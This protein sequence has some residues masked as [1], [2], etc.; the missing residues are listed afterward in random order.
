MQIFHKIDA[1]HSSDFRT[2]IASTHILKMFIR[3][4]DRLRT[5]HSL[6]FYFLIGAAAIENKP[7]SAKKLNGKIIII[8]NSNPI[9]KHILIG[10]RIAVFR[11]VERLYTNSYAFGNFE[12][13]WNL[14]SES[15]NK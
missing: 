2:K 5:N 14:I 6:S 7:M 1:F 13:D 15:T 8:L 10:K 4:Y 11:L 12:H 9:G 3:L